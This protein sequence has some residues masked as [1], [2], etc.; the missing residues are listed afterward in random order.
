MKTRL[1]P[2]L[3][4]CLATACG[5]A[6]TNEETPT[7]EETTSLREGSTAMTTA[8][9]STVL[10]DSLF[11]FDPTIDPAATPEANA[12]AIATHTRSNTMGCGSV[13]VTGASV[14]VSFGAAPGCTLANGLVVSGGV[15]ASVSREGSTTSVSLAFMQL[16]VNGHGVDGSTVFRTQNGSTF[17]VTATLTSGTDSFTGTY[18]VVGTTGAFT[19]T[20]TGSAT[21]AGTTSALQLMGVAYRRGD[22]YPNAG[23]MVVTRGAIT[24]TV[25]FSTA[26]ATTGQV[27]VTQ[28]RRTYTTTLPAYGSCPSS[29]ATPTAQ[30]TASGRR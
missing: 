5:T 19:V 12:E 18:T 3:A 26:S 24:M 14:A 30:P 25:A 21:R 20:G 1:L 16:V 28:G 27:T 4:L 15:T 22:C 9:Q 6:A 7:E 23:T 10:A 8:Q 11:D 29:S 2:A 13:T 17:E